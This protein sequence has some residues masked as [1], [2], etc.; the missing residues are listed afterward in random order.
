M[1]LKKGMIVEVPSQ[2]YQGTAPAELL[3]KDEDPDLDELM[4][5]VDISRPVESTIL[6]RW[7][8]RFVKDPPNHTYM[9]WIGPEQI[10]K[11]GD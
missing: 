3:W 2:N 6:E 11:D 10:I 8:V 1:E 5:P 9:R 4:D 7:E